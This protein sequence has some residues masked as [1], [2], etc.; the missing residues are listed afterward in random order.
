[1]AIDPSIPLQI[2][3][4]V[5]PPVNMLDT[6]GKYQG[7][8]NAMATND[9]IQAHTAQTKQATAQSGNEVM[10]RGFAQFQ[11]L[12]RNLQTQASARQLIDS[13]F[14]A[15]LMGN[16]QY[17]QG[18][19]A[20]DGA[21][22]HASL[23]NMAQRAELYLQSPEQRAATLHGTDTLVN[24]GGDIQPQTQSSPM[25]RDI[26]RNNGQP[27]PAGL[28][29][30]GGNIGN[31]VTPGELAPPRQV[32]T[33]KDG[34][35]IF[36]PGLAVTPPNLVSPTMGGTAGQGGSAP[37]PRGGPP[38]G[39]Q[40]PAHNIPPSLNGPMPGAPSAPAP[41]LDV[42]NQPLLRP[43]S[44]LGPGGTYQPG[45]APARTASQT[46]MGAGSGKRF[47]EIADMGNK[48]QATSA[49]I[50]N[51]LSDASIVKTGPGTDLYKRVARVLQAA[52]MPMDADKITS[53]ESINKNLAQMITG[54]NAP[55][56][57][58]MGVVQSGSPSYDMSPQGFD[59]VLKQMA[60][61]ANWAKAYSQLAANASP[62]EKADSPSF[63]ARMRKELNPQAFQLDQLHGSEAK[64]FLTGL[65]DQQRAAVMNDYRRLKTQGL[66]GG[67]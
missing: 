44:A 48:A 40:W 45:Q 35:P 3:Q 19:V 53:L 55:T 23:M 49:L 28:T 25:G 62:A 67:Q 59:Y 56:D 54:Q 27:V 47:L 10:L 7:I 15:G 65:P 50:G 20:I 41:G 5:A 14:N 34:N 2:G 11:A 38:V 64:M 8:A 21:P 17:H 12:P 51:T 31:T 18:L 39:G 36:A 4:G 9:A 26:A 6:Y 1:M 57:A 61:T 46:E 63:D 42:N 24:T 66:F 16:Q 13:F 58:R 33:E 32:G 43:G 60:G 37:T 52:G 30:T 29:P 22:D